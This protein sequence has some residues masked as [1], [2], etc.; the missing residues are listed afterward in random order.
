MQR[1]YSKE[2]GMA[3]IPGRL[4]TEKHCK[5]KSSKCSGPVALKRQLHVKF[6]VEV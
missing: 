5:V 3:L 4:F 6:K 2:P 1:S